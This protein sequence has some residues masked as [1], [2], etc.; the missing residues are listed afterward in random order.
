MG[1]FSS[2]AN[3]IR[4]KAASPPAALNNQGAAIAVS[5]RHAQRGSADLLKLYKNNDE[6]RKVCAKVAD[7]VGSVRWRVKRNGKEQPDHELAKLLRAPNADMSG[8]AH[9]ALV[10]LYMDLVGESF[11]LLLA[12]ERRGYRWDV[13][14]VPPPDVQL[15][16][17]G[18]SVRL[19]GRSIDIPRGLFVWLKHHDPCD[20]YGRGVGPALALADDILI[21]EAAGKWTS[22]FFRNGARPDLIMSMPGASESVV[23]AA[24][25]AWNNRYQGEQL[26]HQVAFLGGDW[27]VTE[28]Q[29]KVRDLALVEVRQQ[30]AD[31]IREMYGVPPEIFGQLDSSNRATASAARQLFA[32]FVVLPRLEM[33]KREWEAKLLPALGYTD[34][35]LEYDS[36][37]PDDIEGRR[38]LMKA[39]PEA[40]TLN[41]VRREAGLP[42]RKGADVYLRRPGFAEVSAGAI[43]DLTDQA[44]MLP[45]PIPQRPVLRLI[46]CADLTEHLE[47]ALAQLDGITPELLATSLLRWRAAVDGGAAQLAA[48]EQELARAAQELQI[49]DYSSVA[50]A[51][52]EAA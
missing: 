9:R 29:V 41:E 48:A 20:P 22:A 43:E 31:A 38:A 3:I 26:A 11:D 37:L 1:L 46:R 50:Q 7:S 13:C 6:L 32:E 15:T 39:H 2:L 16:P 34:I 33:L 5:A 19:G 45:P 25:A 4:P 51:L 42:A 24:R 12:S 40:F 49:H 17:A 35:E 30:A 23:N 21:S 27:M 18:I 36:P 52:R 44:R 28:M 47:A 10:T 8:P 14:P